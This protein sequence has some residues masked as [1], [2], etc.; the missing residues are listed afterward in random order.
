[1]T[2][3]LKPAD[4][5]N[6]PGLTQLIVGTGGSGLGRKTDRN[7]VRNH[8]D[9]INMPLERTMDQP[10]ATIPN[11]QQDVLGVVVLTLH[12]DT[13]PPKG[14]WKFIG[15][16]NNLSRYQEDETVLA[17]GRFIGRPS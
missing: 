9:K 10:P 3:E 2:E 14:E 7:D 6:G 12:S 5:T 17:S 13:S 4:A 15:V 16:P 8:L 11:Y 1:M